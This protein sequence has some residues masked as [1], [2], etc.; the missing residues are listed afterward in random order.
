MGFPHQPGQPSRLSSAD[1]RTLAGRAADGDLRAFEVLVRRYGPLMRTYA[2]RIL[3]S[4][5]ET[6]DV[7]QEAFITAW[8][9]LHSLTNLSAVRGWLLTIVTH[10][11]ID[12]VRARARRT[13][14]N[15]DD[16]DD[17]VS[18][19]LTP[20]RSAE[21]GSFAEALSAALSG[22]SD[23]QRRCWVLRMVSNYSYE[24]I[25][26]QLNLP[27]STVRG[28]LARARK[29]LIRELEVWRD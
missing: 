16:Y 20:E 8:Q 29:T 28:L 10:R 6:D 7:V 17:L 3:G 21:A 5:D 18:A 4:T 12:R 27:T 22:L 23:D 26:S 24:E 2:H 14:D 13:H 25:G 15:I 19:R 1:D 9:Q 11:A